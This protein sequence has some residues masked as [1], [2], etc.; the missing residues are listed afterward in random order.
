MQLAQYQPPLGNA[1]LIINTSIYTV[2]YPGIPPPPP[3]WI[4]SEVI[5]QSDFVGND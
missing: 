1:S 5:A 4:R 2:I 3:P